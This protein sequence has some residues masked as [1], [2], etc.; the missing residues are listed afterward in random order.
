MILNGFDMIWCSLS[1]DLI[2]LYV[3]LY[4]FFAWFLL[5]F[6]HG[7]ECGFH[8]ILNEGMVMNTNAG[9]DMS[10]NVGIDMTTH[11]W[12]SLRMCGW[13][14]RTSYSSWIIWQVRI[15]VY[16][17]ISRMSVFLRISCFLALLGTPEILECPIPRWY[18]NSE[19][20]CTT[21]FFECP[22]FPDVIFSE[23][24]QYTP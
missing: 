14:F 19:F 13:I 12:P 16:P 9:I 4:C 23:T 10:T 21:R 24:L 17:W 1:Y 20:P 5:R 2:L 6:S 3:T 22:L 15:S 8:K 18:E 7:F 11:V